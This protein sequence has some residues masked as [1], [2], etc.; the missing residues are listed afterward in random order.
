MAEDNLTDGNPVE[1][2]ACPSKP[3]LGGPE[4]AR[5]GNPAGITGRTPEEPTENKGA[6]PA[7]A[8]PSKP[9]LGGPETARENI[10]GLPDCAPKEPSFDWG[11][12][13]DDDLPGESWRYPLNISRVFSII[14]LGL[15]SV[16]FFVMPYIMVWHG[17]RLQKMMEGAEIVVPPLAAFF[18][19]IITCFK[20]CLSFWFLPSLVL[21]GLGLFLEF[22]FKGKTRW[23]NLI[24][25]LVVSVLC[26]A[27]VAVSR[28]ALVLPVSE[29]FTNK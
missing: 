12:I 20:L 11:M 17:I 24:L 25:C 23:I 9:A 15:M 6:D 19:K 14:L 28:L 3:A 7:K 26:W 27:L 5:E 4:T 2:N 18:L 10:S 29:A 22:G 1:K 8:C 16:S 13:D 21:L